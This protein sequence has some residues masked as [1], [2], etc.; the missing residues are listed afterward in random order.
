M[1]SVLYSAGL[2][3][4]AGNPLR[5]EITRLH[6][7]VDQLRKLLELANSEMTIY[8]KYITLSFEKSDKDSDKSF[9]D[10][11]NSELVAIDSERAAVL[12]PVVQETVAKGGNSVATTGRYGL[13]GSRGF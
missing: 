10:K 7:D 12:P 8:R 11:M 5:S 4:Q 2:N 13:A 6:R 1:S 9:V 3:Y